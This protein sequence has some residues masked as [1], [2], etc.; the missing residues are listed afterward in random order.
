MQFSGSQEI[1]ASAYHPHSQGNIE[2]MNG[3]IK[4]KL[5]I[6]VSE[7]QKD[8]CKKLA[9]CMFVIR[10]TPSETRGYSPFMIL[11]GQEPRFSL[12]QELD[13][14]PEF[15][16][17]VHERLADFAQRI[18]HIRIEVEENLNQAKKS[19]KAKYD[20]TVRGPTYQVGDLVCISLSLK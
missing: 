6:L 10:A 11:Y 16:A 5:A 4:T 17:P 18:D 2:R 1:E 7:N 14:D 13:L 9:P 20:E 12:Q 3:V 15:P 19:T 8:W